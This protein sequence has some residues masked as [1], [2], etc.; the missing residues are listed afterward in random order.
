MKN[1]SSEGKD[2]LKRAGNQRM[3]DEK[4]TRVV[5]EKD[6]CPHGRCWSMNPGSGRGPKEDVC[7]DLRAV[8]TTRQLWEVEEQ[9][10]LRVSLVT[11]RSCSRI[12]HTRETVKCQGRRTS[13]LDTRGWQDLRTFRWTWALAEF[14]N[15]AGKQF[16]AP[17]RSFPWVTRWLTMPNLGKEQ[18]YLFSSR[19]SEVLVR[20]QPQ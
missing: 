10:K 2:K 20:D 4:N 15:L 8:E 3:E 11:Q 18:E 1:N 19:Q 16:P 7:G 6:A 5:T 14:W 9:G 12:E 17:I 13:G